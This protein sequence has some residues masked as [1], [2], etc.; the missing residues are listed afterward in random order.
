MQTSC[1]S[2]G[3]RYN[4]NDQQIAGHA[5]VQ[6]RCAKCGKTTVVR[7]AKQPERTAVISAMPTL[8]RAERSGGDASA[9]ISEFQ[10]L[11]LPADKTITLAVTEGPA[12]GLVHELEKPRVILGR[13]GADV[14]LNDPGISR[15]HCAIEVNDQVVRLRDLESTNGTYFEEERVRAAEL[16]HGAEFRIGSTVVQLRIVPKQL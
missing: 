9:I 2:C 5:Q 6:F 13:E 4:L 15:R 12:K 1:S 14:P 11:V 10:G 7:L 16:S 8:G 3:A